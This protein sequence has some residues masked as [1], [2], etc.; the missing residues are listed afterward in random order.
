MVLHARF[1][2]RASVET[3]LGHGT[4]KLVRIRSPFRGVSVS[5]PAGRLCVS[6][7]S[8]SRVIDPGNLT[9]AQRSADAL[10]HADPPGKSGADN[11]WPDR[12][13]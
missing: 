8:A 10:R 9:G 12:R 5:E 3:S 13:L 4:A 6:R 7:A 11:R 2:V 1:F